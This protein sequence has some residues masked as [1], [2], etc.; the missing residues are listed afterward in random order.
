[1]KKK[2]F[3]LIELLA[4]IIILAILA[5][6]LIPI[7][8]DL[9]ANARYG[10]AANS[11][12]NYVNAAN[13]Q[14][15]VEVGGFEEYKLNLPEEN[16]L[17]TGVTD[18]ELDKIKYKGKGPTYIY[19]HFSD[20]GKVVDEGRFCIWGYSIDYN[21]IDGTSKGAIDYCNDPEPEG[22]LSCDV[23]NNNA[24]NDTTNFVIKTIEDLVCISEMSN[25]GKNFQGKKVYLAKNIDFNNNSS[26]SDPNG[27][28]FGD[29]NGNGN[30]EGLKV[31]LTTEKGFKP[32]GT[33]K[34]IFEGYTKKISNLMI[35]RPQDD[36][37]FVS[38]NNGTIR[39]L[40]LVNVD[41]T[42]A[43]HVGGVV[44]NNRGGTVNEIIISGKVKGTG[45]EVAGVVGYQ[46]GGGNVLSAYVKDI[47]VAGAGMVANGWYSTVKGV[48]ESGTVAWRCTNQ[49]SGSAT[50]VTYCSTNVSYGEAEG[51]LY[52]PGE[53]MLNTYDRVL[54]TYIG[55]DN[56]NSGYYFDYA[57]N[58]SSDIVIKSTELSP[59]KFTLKGSGTVE[60][61][62][63]ID[64]YKHF[65]EATTMSNGNYVFKITEDI[66]FD[67][68]HF[69]SLGTLGNPLGSNINGDMHTLSNIVIT[70][71]DTT[72]FVT[73]T[74]GHTIEGIKFDNIKVS[75]N[76]SNV[77]AIAGS[78]TGTIKGIVITNATVSGV[79][80]VG[81]VVGNNNTG[82]VNEV[83][84]SGKVSGTGND[85][86]GVVGYQN[87]NSYTTSAYVKD[88]EVI[89]SEGAG[90]VS[91]GW[92]STIK[93]VIESGKVSAR[94]A[95]ENAGSSTDIT[96]CS[97]TVEVGDRTGIA[98]TPGEYMINLYD[99]VLDTYIGG[100]ND[101]S[102]YYFDYENETSNN[103]VLVR[104]KDKPITFT[105]QGSGTVDDPYLI[106]SYK[107]YKEATTKSNGN[108]VFKIT[109]DIDFGGKH[110]YSLGTMGNP[111]G[112]NI[113]GDMHTLSNIVIE[114]AE[115]TG[116]IFNING[117]T[118]EGLNLANIKVTSKY[119]KVGGI[120]GLNNGLIKGIN[121]INADISGSSRVGGIA[122][123]NDG[124][125]VNEVTVTGKISG[126]GNDIAGVVGYQYGGGNIVTSALV[127]DIEVTGG[128][129]TGIVSDG[130]YSTIKGVIESGS[131]SSRCTTHNAGMATDVCYCS[132]LVRPGERT[133]RAYTL[134]PPTTVSVSGSEIDSLTYYDS[135]GVLD[136]VIGGDNDD[137]GYYLQYN[138]SADS[139]I[140]VKAGTP[141]NPSNPGNTN[142]D[143]PVAITGTPTGTNPPT[144]VLNQVIPRSN[145]IQAVLTCEDEEGAPTIRSQW[146]VN[147]GAPTNTFAD[148]G[149]VKNGT[150][151]GN[152]KIVRPYWSTN[153]P[154]SIP[155]RGDCYYYRFGA[156]DASGNWTYYVTN[157]CYHA[158]LD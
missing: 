105:L 68:K 153:D 107:Q 61:P 34:G 96:Y 28:S 156:Q 127:H 44:G 149:I 109:N 3:T 47:E 139:I 75:A 21:N 8:Q 88:V 101:N 4:V 119:S 148:I 134:I 104:T 52:T 89:G 152:S 1:M 6:I 157:E 78:N 116:F 86:G 26:Y 17:E 74:N 64:S 83:V 94:C 84:M 54:D 126:T 27:T 76:N 117:H 91:D 16:E 77:G 113:N 144:C 55:G 19:L 51:S 12:M 132:S 131:V 38:V 99:R 155:H 108:Y 32:I 65:K 69:Y 79:S 106:D 121:V 70:G 123:Q 137:S 58:N 35:N 143:S 10:A 129:G 122:G 36:V 18:E 80:K 37:G 115:N 138:N 102:G 81:G 60:D 43:N 145:G 41:I 14:A 33:F 29:I 11:V 118:V 93:G 114:G 39:G 22:V 150:V 71:A 20:D 125:T 45:S 72:G 25:N 87:R 111:L 9:I 92:Y 56:D 30:V 13:T 73:H 100:D 136:T 120:V 49:N 135:Q 46:Y 130:W 95:N 2:G 142:P 40:T 57:G 82:T 128:E 42:G 53:Y 24:Y 66:D 62:Y 110:F 15:A 85:I 146:N 151:N 158:F 154:I 90:I 133:G 48:V 112:S 67:G 63:I 103:I 59:I 50:L 23:L 5:F 147:A 97:S 7:I 98:Y 31:E 141:S 140:V 124:G